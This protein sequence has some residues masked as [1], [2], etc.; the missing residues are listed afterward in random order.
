M[1]AAQKGAFKRNHKMTYDTGASMT[2]MSKSMLRK[3]GEDPKRTT[4]VTYTSTQGAIGPATLLVFRWLHL[5][6]A[7]HFR[8]SR[9][10]ASG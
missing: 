3:I 9:T 6:R 2:T 1:S 4:N 8:T 7:G 5:P 10:K